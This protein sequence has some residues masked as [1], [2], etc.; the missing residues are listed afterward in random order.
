[1][2]RK[3]RVPGVLAV[4]LG[5]HIRKVIPSYRHINKAGRATATIT[6]GRI[7]THVAHAV[8]CCSRLR[9]ISGQDGRTSVAWKIG[10]EKGG[11]FV[12]WRAL[13]TRDALEFDELG[14][15]VAKRGCGMANEAARD[16]DWE[17]QTLRA[18]IR[19]IVGVCSVRLYL[20][21]KN[22]SGKRTPI[23]L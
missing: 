17:M 18:S 20:S 6:V 10:E 19:L 9:G 21:P 13:A 5:L 2:S 4:N 7:R 14:Q 15:E 12:V 3:M 1:M 8:L 22:P 23:F 11:C 16:R